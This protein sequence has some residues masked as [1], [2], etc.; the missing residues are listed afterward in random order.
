MNYFIINPISGSHDQRKKK[1]LLSLIKSYPENIVFETKCKNDEIELTQ[2]AIKLG[3]NK[4]I[5]VGGDGTINKVAS[6]L[7]ETDIPMGIIPMGSGNGLARHLKIPLTVEK[8]LNKAMHGKHIKIDAC[9]I[10]DKY[11]FCTSG[12]GFDAL[13]ADIFEKRKKRGLINYIIAVIIALM[14]YEPIEAKVNSG[15]TEK[16]FLLTISN[17]NQYGNNAYISPNAD[18]QDGQFEIIKIRNIGKLKLAMIALRLFSKSIHR[19]QDVEIVTGNNATIELM[20]KQLLHLDGDIA[21]SEYNNL[22]IKAKHRV[23][24]V[25]A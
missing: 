21:S 16:I 12:I 5:A 25:T 2:K 23:L 10:N 7:I 4:I 18:I 24:I 6:V 19:S 20:G 22:T 13:V 14:K 8:A 9:S 3:A 17:A 15:P 11:S 1:Q